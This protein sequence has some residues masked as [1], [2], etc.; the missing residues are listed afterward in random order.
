[1]IRVPYFQ[2]ATITDTLTCIPWDGS[3]GGVLILN[4]ATDVI[5]NAPID[6]SRKGFRGGQVGA[7][8]SCNNTGNWAVQT[9]TGGTKGEG[10]TEYI[11]RFEAGGAKLANG[12]GGSYSANT[13]GGGGANYGEGG[14]GGLQSNTCGSQTQSIGGEAIN[15]TDLSRVCM[16]GAGGGGQQDDGQPVAAGGNGGGIVIIKATLFNGNNQHITAIGES[17]TTLVRDEGGA[18]GGAG[19]SVLLYVDGYTSTVTVDINGGDGSSNENQV[20]PSRCHGPGGGGGGGYIGFKFGPVPP[21]V[22]VN[23][24]GGKAGLILNP[25]S[26]CFNTTHGALDGTDGGGN[27]NIILPEATVPFKKNIDSV[28]IK[29]S[30]TACKSFDFKGTAF[31]N[32]SPVQN[33]QWSF[34]DGGIANVQDAFHTYS[35]GGNYTI[36]LIVTDINGCKDSTEKI[37]NPAGI[38]FDFVF[39]QDACNPRAVIFRAVGDTTAG[40]FWSLGDG[41]VINNIR[42]PLHVYADTGYYLVQYSTGNGVCV[43]TVRKTIYIGYKNSNI[44]ITPDTTICFGTSKLLRSNIDSSLNFCWSPASF[45]NNVNFANPTTSTP[46]NIMYSLLAVSEENN[47]V[48]NGNFSNGNTGFGSEY[49]FNNTGTFPPGQYAISSFSSGA[50][51]GSVDCKDHTTASGNMLVASSDAANKK[52][53]QQTVSTVPNSN[54]IFSFWLQ[55]VSGAAKAQLQLSI[56]GNTVLD[57]IEN[58]L[59]TCNWQRHFVRWNA[60]NNTTAQLAI[61]DRTIPKFVNGVDNFAI[62]DI[63]FATYSIKRDTVNITVDTPFVDTRSDTAICKSIPVPLNTTGAVSYSWSPV[64]GLSNGFIANPVA[65]SDTTTKYILSGINANGCTAKD[66]VII[67]IKPTPAIIKTGDTIVC[68]N[69]AV[70]LFAGG[71]ASYAWSPAGSLNN[72]NIPNPVANPAANTR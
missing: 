69:T 48:T 28:K 19:G 14:I 8:F 43:D 38:N 54:Y 16:G 18:G 17:I 1:M 33:W 60:G 7:G 46:G 55:G 40:I 39:E 47:L 6:V 3:K 34:G 66:S 22:A 36:K 44:I 71:G 35:A 62:D 27:V 26:T 4:S 45:L 72:A 29:D 41:T 68:R 53:W 49:T 31:T 37:I 25:S 42:N 67:T 24:S 5:L 23:A 12:G 61:A 10:I 59:T 51:V 57:S 30:I 70:P 15:Y 21:G 52:I 32:T 20:Y 2:T 58:P 64:A 65:M 63:S 13:G 50:G 11:S 56:N 9:G